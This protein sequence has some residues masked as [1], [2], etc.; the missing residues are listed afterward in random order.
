VTTKPGD[1]AAST[2][3]ILSIVQGT[4]NPGIVAGE[5]AMSHIGYRHLCFSS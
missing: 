5:L 4:L 1:H 2:N 3:D